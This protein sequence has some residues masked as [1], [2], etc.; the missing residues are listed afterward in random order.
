MSTCCSSKLKSNIAKKTNCIQCGESSH[1]VAF[2][3]VLH[4]IVHPSNQNLREE[5]LYFCDSVICPV[6][7]FSVDDIIFTQESLRGPVGQ[8]S[9][10]PLRTICYCFDVTAQQVLDELCIDGLSPSK[11]FVVNQ[12]KEKNCAC[13]I[14]NPSGRCCL[15][16]FPTK[17]EV[18][19]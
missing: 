15:A 8:K 16:N 10:D 19:K 3:T 7:Y 6:I 18:V 4:H 2:K 12:T 1:S 9:N 13:E 14:R 5:I 11:E 17:I